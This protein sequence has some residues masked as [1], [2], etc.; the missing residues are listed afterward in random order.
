MHNHALTD[1]DGSAEYTT[2]RYIYFSYYG[3]AQLPAKERWMWKKLMREKKIYP[4]LA[5]TEGCEYYREHYRTMK[6]KGVSPML[7]KWIPTPIGYAYVI[8][9]NWVSKLL[10]RK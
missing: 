4:M 9:R 6:I 3:I 10:H 1:R 8:I 2:V 5:L 7:F